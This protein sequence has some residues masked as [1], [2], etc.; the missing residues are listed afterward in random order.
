MKNHHNCARH[1]AFYLKE[2]AMSLGMGH[3]VIKQPGLVETTSIVSS[4]LG[5]RLAFDTSRTVAGRSRRLAELNTTV[6]ETIIRGLTPRLPL[7]LTLSPS[8]VY[9]ATHSAHARS[10]GNPR[11]LGVVSARVHARVRVTSDSPPPPLARG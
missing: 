4:R 7:P 11:N 5:K 9:I 1:I 3:P 6:N 10:C 8:S 2:N